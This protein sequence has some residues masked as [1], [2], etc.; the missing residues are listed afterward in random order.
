M[1]LT[2]LYITKKPFAAGKIIVHFLLIC[3]VYILLLC[4]AAMSE[5]RKIAIIPFKINSPKE[6]SYVRNGIFQMM[7]SRLAW[8]DNVIVA[9]EQEVNKS[10]INYMSHSSA[11]LEAGNSKN[12]AVAFNKT[13]TDYPD[14]ESSGLIA[15]VAADTGSDYVIQGSITQFAGAFSVDATVFNISQSISRS[16]FT[17]AETTEKI[18][19]GVEILSAQINMDIFNRTTAALTLANEDKNRASLDTIRANP[20]KLMP[21]VTIENSSKERP[22][23]KFWGKD[24]PD[25]DENI[26]VSGS[27]YDNNSAVQSGSNGS[28]RPTQLEP[29]EDIVINTEAEA[30]DDEKANKKP[31]WKFW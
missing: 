19:P 14:M 1:T 3:L 31:F 17:Q 15:K 10:I 23:W 24:K 13:D 25:E 18:I 9:T 5:T 30:D 8:K 21:Q 11:S 6:I 26:A 29:E 28:T 16:F 22:F 7:S 20:E 4:P 27:A 2:N 12:I